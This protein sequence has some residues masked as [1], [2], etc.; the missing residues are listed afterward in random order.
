MKIRRPALLRQQFVAVAA[1]LVTAS[2]VTAIAFRQSLA[3]TWEQVTTRQSEQFTSLAFLSAGGLPTYAP[4]N[5]P[6]HISFRIA[7][8]ESAHMAYQYRVILSTGS[9]ATLLKTDT[10]EL[11]DGQMSDQTITFSLANPNTTNEIVVQLVGRSEYIT[12][13]VKS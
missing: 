1:I 6:Q 5:T 7:N 8:H 2:F 11:A 13:E 12:F 3:A 10:V 4:A 9:T